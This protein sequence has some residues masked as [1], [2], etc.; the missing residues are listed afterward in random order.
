MDPI[1]NLTSVGTRD[2]TK[3]MLARVIDFLKR[4]RVT[5]LFT[6]LV[7]GGADLEQTEVGISSF[8]DTWLFLKVIESAGERNRLLYL[9][10]SRGMAH[11]NQVREFLLTDDG[12]DLVD[13]YTGPGA[14]YT[15]SSRVVQEQADRADALSRQVAARRKGRELEGERAG[16]EG[17]IRAL[18]SRLKGLEEEIRLAGAQETERLRRAAA[19]RRALSDI[20]RADR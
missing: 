5:A 16:L 15:G 3:A 13:V 6:S 1:T 10:K 4:E 9:L 11:S 18:Q 14:V 7:V 8:M 17:Q 12:I 20:R 2:E 19:D